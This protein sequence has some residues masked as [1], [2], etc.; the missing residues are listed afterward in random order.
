MNNTLNTSNIWST[1][2]NI[3]L[4]SNLHISLGSIALCYFTSTLLDISI[5]EYYYSFVFFSTLFLYSIHRIIG[6]SR[7]DSDSE[8]GRFRFIRKIKLLLISS[9]IISVIALLYSFSYLP[10]EIQLYLTIPGILSLGYS[11][12]FY[13]NK[14]LRDLPF[15]KLFLIATAWSVI[16]VFIP[17]LNHDLPVHQI[18]LLTAAIFFYF[19]GITIPFDIRDLKYDKIT[20]VPTFPIYF[21]I[22]KSILFSQLCLGLSIALYIILNLLDVQSTWLFIYLYLFYFYMMI[23]IRKYKTKEADWY[24]TGLL[25]GTMIL[26][27]VIRLFT[28]F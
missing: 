26:H 11:I 27:A 21:G 8:T 20:M 28:M 16:V 10:R 24:Y 23:T 7:I 9:S 1:I 13:K 4:Y 12:P 3:Y 17:S 6:L 5:S 15:I 22:E 18:V 25:D 14:R 19:I 2:L